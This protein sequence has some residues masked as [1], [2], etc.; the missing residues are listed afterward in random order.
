M[1][2]AFTGPSAFLAISKIMNMMSHT[3]FAAHAPVSAPLI[4]GAAQNHSAAKA[5]QGFALLL[6]I[7]AARSMRHPATRMM[8]AKIH[9]MDH[10]HAPDHGAHQ[11]THARTVMAMLSAAISDGQKL[12]DNF[13]GNI[14]ASFAPSSQFGNQCESLVYHGVSNNVQTLAV[15]QDHQT[16]LDIE[17]QANVVIEHNKSRF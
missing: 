9:R 11:H 1:K 13:G 17:I 14:T 16:G 7:A 12:T 10:R 4:G 2:A 6:A 5:T 3:G 8:Q 15:N